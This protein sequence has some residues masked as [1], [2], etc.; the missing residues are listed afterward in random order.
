MHALPL[1]KRLVSVT[2]LFI[3]WTKTR[4]AW[5]DTFS[6]DDRWLF[7]NLFRWSSSNRIYDHDGKLSKSV[8][9]QNGM[10]SECV[11]ST[12]IYSYNY[13]SNYPLCITFTLFKTV[14]WSS[15][16]ICLRHH[17]MY[18]DNWSFIHSCLRENYP[19]EFYLVKVLNNINLDRRR[20][21]TQTCVR[22]YI[23]TLAW[24]TVD[25]LPRSGIELTQLRNARFTFHG[26][27]H[28]TKLQTNR[29]QYV[30]PI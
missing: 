16:W 23:S 18:S 29:C 19:K 27:P 13:W 1:F 6:R 3:S 20:R 17:Y 28:C 25:Q 4:Q 8:Y 30:V 15:F 24:N 14:V 2:N 22:L 5:F 12:Y 21:Q 26:A 7:D 10:L 9:Y 11:G